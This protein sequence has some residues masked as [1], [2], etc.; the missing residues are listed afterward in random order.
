MSKIQNQ[1]VGV[2]LKCNSIDSKDKFCF[3][4]KQKE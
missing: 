1:V 4:K 3:C 2:A